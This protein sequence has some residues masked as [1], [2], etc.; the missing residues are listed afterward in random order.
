MCPIVPEKHY[1]TCFMMTLYYW[2]Y[3]SSSLI[4]HTLNQCASVWKLFSDIEL[5][6]LS[7]YSKRRWISKSITLMNYCWNDIH[8][9]FYSS[10]ITQ[11]IYTSYPLTW[12][13]Q[14]R[15]RSSGH[16]HII[17]CNV[18]IPTFASHCFQYQLH[19]G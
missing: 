1:Y 17:N 4:S 5:R 6:S 18:S 12:R 19:K 11:P 10:K 9:F 7:N 8:I 3:I 14:F 15:T 16:S 2:P 13:V